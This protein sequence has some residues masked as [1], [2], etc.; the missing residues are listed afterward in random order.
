MKIVKLTFELNDEL[1]LKSVVI[2]WNETGLKND[3]KLIR[4]IAIAI[5]KSI[6]SDPT[7]VELQ[8]LYNELGIKNPND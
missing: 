5:I 8:D 6:A 2:D 1:C 3:S 7:G 4:G